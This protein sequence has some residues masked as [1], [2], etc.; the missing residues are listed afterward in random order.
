LAGELFRSKIRQGN[1]KEDWDDPDGDDEGPRRVGMAREHSGAGEFCRT[2]RYPDAGRVAAGAAFRITQA[3]HRHSS[4]CRRPT[5][6]GRHSTNCEGKYQRCPEWEEAHRR[7][8]PK[9]ARRDRAG[10][11]RVQWPCWGSRWGGGPHGHQPDDSHLP[12]A[13]TGYRSHAV[14]LLILKR[15]YRP[16]WPARPLRSQITVCSI[17]AAVAELTSTHSTHFITPDI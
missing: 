7:V 13:E 8:C 6:A 2:C 12:H 3:N 9:A 17:H 11:H 15:L 14:R 16:L 1:A 5:R 10:P 4:C